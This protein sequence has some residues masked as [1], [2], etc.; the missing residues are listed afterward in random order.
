MKPKPTFLRYMGE[1]GV[2]RKG[3]CPKALKDAA[4]PPPRSPK[5]QACRHVPHHRPSGH[6]S[7]GC[8]LSSSG[9][10]G[11]PNTRPCTSALDLL[12]PFPTP[13]CVRPVPS[14]ASISGRSTPGP[15][16]YPQLSPTE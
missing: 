5:S 7:A 8:L 9:H 16:P 11:F 15:S 1:P 2:Q 6:H 3:T 12:L 4:T 14:H 10:P 13:I